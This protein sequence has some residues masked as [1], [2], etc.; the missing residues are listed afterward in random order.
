M[1][2]KNIFF[3]YG[4]EDYLMEEEIDRLKSMMT[5]ETV[6]IAVERFTPDDC[7]PMNLLQVIFTPS[8]FQNERLIVVSGYG[9]EDYLEILNGAENI[10]SGIILVITEKKTDKRTKFFKEVQKRAVVKEFKAFAQ[11]ETAKIISR[12]ISRSSASSKKMDE[13]TAALLNEVSGPSLRQLAS[14]IEKLSTYAGGRDSITSEDVRRL[15]VSGELG[16]FAVENAL[17]SRDIKGALSALTVLMRSKERAEAILGRI[18]SRIRTYLMIKSL[19]SAGRSRDE[20]IKRMGMNPYYFERCEDG[21]SS[22]C[23]DELCAAV[24]KLSKA[25]LDLKTTMK[26]A[27]VVMQLLITD[28]LAKGD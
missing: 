16:A 6:N 25:D 27:D 23:L 8:L 4:D 2:S 15:A 22:Y 18:A 9:E 7:D 17:A 10:P 5:T 12:I 11:W 21:A 19:Q 3:F 13:K 14:E 26:P 28:I 1:G 24:N 20:I